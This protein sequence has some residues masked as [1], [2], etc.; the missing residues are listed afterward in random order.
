MHAFVGKPYGIKTNNKRDWY[1]QK[2]HCSLLIILVFLPIGSF[3]IL[4]FIKKYP[5]DMT[6]SL[7]NVDSGG[8]YGCM[9]Y[10]RN[11]LIIAVVVS[12]LGTALAVFNAYMTARNRTKLSY[13]LH[14]MSITSL[15]IPGLVLGLSYVMFFK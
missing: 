13:V 6:L 7:S 2:Y 4:G 11:S 5:I 10:L 14:L 8:Q 12:F 1:C 9:K 3:A 15:A